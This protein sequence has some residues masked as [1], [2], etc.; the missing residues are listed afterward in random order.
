MHFKIT[1][2]G[3]QHSDCAMCSLN[4][5]SP[6]FSMIPHTKQSLLPLLSHA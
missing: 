5:L 4:C 3:K 6:R 1:R 2:K